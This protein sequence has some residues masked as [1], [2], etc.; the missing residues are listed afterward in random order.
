MENELAPSSIVGTAPNS[1]PWPG[2]TRP[3]CPYPQ[4]AHYKGSGDI[5]VAAN[6]ECRSDRADDEAD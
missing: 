6:F 2:R 4:Y 5:N 3:L 1:T